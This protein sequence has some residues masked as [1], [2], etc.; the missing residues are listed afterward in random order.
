MDR[1]YLELEDEN[2]LGVEISWEEKIKNANQKEVK[3][4]NE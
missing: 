2:F 4:R 3:N 1:I